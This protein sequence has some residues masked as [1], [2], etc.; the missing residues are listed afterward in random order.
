MCPSLRFNVEVK[1]FEGLMKT[2]ETSVRFAGAS[3]EIRPE[4]ISN[5]NVERYRHTKLLDVF[6]LH[7]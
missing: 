7:E 6:R 1:Y 3:A 2:T 5:A 4:H